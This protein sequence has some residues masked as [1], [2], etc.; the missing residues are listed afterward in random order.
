DLHRQ[1][2]VFDTYGFAPRAA[3]DPA[4]MTQLIEAGASDLEVQDLRE[5]LSMTQAAVVAA[6]RAE[7]DEAMRCRGVTAIFQNAGEEGQDPLRLLKR[8]ARFTFLA[9][10]LRGTLVRATLPDD[11]EAAHRTGQ[12]CLYLTGNGVPLPQT[13]V[14]VEEELSY[15]R[16]F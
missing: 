10:R 6:E 1:T 13:W 14:T 11:I 9:D 15:I 7:F 16:L 3:L 8:L 12:H 4:R 5:E 2:L